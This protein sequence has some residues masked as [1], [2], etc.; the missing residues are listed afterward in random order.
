MTAR[1][2]LV[3]AITVGLADR[4]LAQTADAAPAAFEL[5]TSIKNSVLLTRW[6][7]DAVLFP[8][9]RSATGL[10]R[11]RLEPSVRWS[12]RAS[13][14][15]AFEQRLSLFSSTAA[16]IG[17]GVLPSA[18]RA[19]FRVTQLD[20]RFARSTHAEWRGEIDR[21]AVRLHGASA[22][23]TIGRQPIGWG[24]GVVF[25]AIDLF[26]PFA[27]L[28]ADREWRR[29]VDAVR[30]DLELGDRVSLD[31]VAALDATPGRSAVAARV[32]GYAGSVDLEVAG[33]ARARD[34]FAGAASSAALGPLELHGELALFRPPEGAGRNDEAR[35]TIVKAVAGGSYRVPLRRGVLTYVEYH[36]SGFGSPTAG[37]I[38]MDLQDPAFQ[39]RYLRGDTQ[40][41]G[42]HALAMLASYE[43]S[44]VVLTSGQW[45]HSPADSSGVVI[46]SLN[47]TMS[48]HWSVT[49]SGY[50]PYGPPPAGFQL[51]SQ[52]GGSPLG[53]F[54]QLRVYR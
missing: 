30:V 2:C 37:R 44:P 13:I 29:G 11:V 16:S 23:V 27:P 50:L 8:D 3:V 20:W 45:I 12:E 39:E 24:R 34:V 52:F 17:A 28:E 41:L 9:R 32:R 33:G 26:S 40:I 4:A 54:V 7:D 35:R 6:P 18:A 42:R 53:V 21:A 43:W 48:D 25:G 49:A 51:A 31:G 15:V 46:P 10:W 38:L 36:Y 47:W 5:R 14:D 1:L 22:D 19:P